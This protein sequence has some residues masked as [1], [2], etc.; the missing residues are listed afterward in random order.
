M[1]KELEDIEMT[2]H[3]ETDKAILLSDNGEESDAIWLAKSQI[4][5]EKKSGATNIWIVT[6]PQWMAKKEGLI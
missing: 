2:K 1:P 3:A 4:E 6:M 5:I